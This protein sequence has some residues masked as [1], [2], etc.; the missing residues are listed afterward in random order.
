MGI[1]KEH[2]RLL[3][4]CLVALSGLEGYSSWRGIHAGRGGLKKAALAAEVKLTLA[5]R[6]SRPP[7][8]PSALATTWR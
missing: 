8:A 1:R 3:E 6:S 5:I 2:R 7:T 4:H